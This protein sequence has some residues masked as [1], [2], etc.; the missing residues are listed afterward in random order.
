M[1]VK[2]PFSQRSLIACSFAFATICAISACSPQEAKAP[3][4]ADSASESAAANNTA[5]NTATAN[6]SLAASTARRVEIARFGYDVAS[7]IPTEGNVRDQAKAQEWCVAAMIALGDRAGAEEMANSMRTWRRAACYADIGLSYA[8]AGETAKASEFAER[9][10][11][12]LPEWLDWQQERIRVKVAQVY[13]VL[14]EGG[15]ADELAKGVGEPE[16]GKVEMIEATRADEAEFDARLAEIEAWLA[17][18]NFDLAR[19]ALDVSEALYGR[20]VQDAARRAKIENV[21]RRLNA[22]VPFDLRV[23]SL[24]ELA[25]TASKAGDAAH[26]LELVAEAKAEFNKAKWLP[27]DFVTQMALLGTGEFEAGDSA[28]ARKTLDE[29]V[30]YFQTNRDSIVDIFRGAPLRLVA[31]GYAT[32]GDDAKAREIFALAINEGAINGNARPR[33]E[34][35][36]AACADLATTGVEPGEELWARIAE[37]RAGLRAPW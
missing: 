14:G 26:A 8:R 4:A 19:N 29:A 12:S 21:V 33:A 18:G 22:K 13:V 7:M 6:T 5:S 32:L 30:A 16:I 17:T 3:V 35:L 34:D 1:T 10:L 25:R 15:R 24:L 9:A 37:I 2:K 31:K 20:F 11:K 36:A 27:E 28:G 23:A